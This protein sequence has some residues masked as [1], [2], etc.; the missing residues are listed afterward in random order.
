[1]D[2][3]KVQY[4][5]F[6][7]RELNLKD[8]EDSGYYQGPEAPPGFSYYGV[9]LQ[10]CNPANSSSTPLRAA[11]SNFKIQ[12]TNG[13]VF[14]PMPLPASNIWAYHPRLLKQQACIPGAGSLASSGPTGGAMLLFKIPLQSLENRPFDLVIRAP[15][16]QQGTIELDI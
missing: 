4:N 11:A 5:V 1:M 7:T 6:I 15:N 3:G 16:G 2:I 8:A 13:D 12:D 9:F 14:R 10:A